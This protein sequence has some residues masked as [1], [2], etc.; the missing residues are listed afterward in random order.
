MNLRLQKLDYVF[1]KEPINKDSK[2][3]D[4]SKSLSASRIKTKDKNFMQILL[5]G[6]YDNVD[7]I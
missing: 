3:D 6:R 2:R 4:K 7:P 5:N 1:H